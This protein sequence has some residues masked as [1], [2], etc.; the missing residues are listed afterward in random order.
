VRAVWLE[1]GQVDQGFIEAVAPGFDLAGAYEKAVSVA[2]D[3][4]DTLRTDAQAVAGALKLKSEI[5]ELKENLAANQ[6]RKKSQK[7]RRNAIW[8]EWKQLWQPLGIDPLDPRDMAAWAGR[9]GE[10]RLKAAECRAKMVAVAQLRD[11]M[12]RVGTEMAE[13]LKELGV[14]RPEKAG[15]TA[16]ADLAKQTK[17]HHDQLRKSRQELELRI[18]TLEQ[19][20]DDNQKRKAQAEQDIR[21]WDR[22]WTRAI[23]KLEFDTDAKPEDVNDF[24]LALD[25]VF[26]ELEKVKDKKQRIAGIQHNYQGY[27]KRIGDVLD[28]IAPDL[29]PLEATEA[30][31]ELN[32]RLDKDRAQQMDRKRFEQERRKKSD[33]LS[34]IKQ[35]LAAQREKLRL[36]CEDALT[37]KPEQL[38]EIE[39]R[40]AAHSK[41]LS[42]LDT[43]NERLAELALGQELKTFV[44]QVRV[45][46]PD[47]LVAK[48]GRLD[49]EKK[50]LLQEQKQLVEEIAVQKKELEAIGGD[51]LAAGIAEQVQGLSGKIASDVEH[52]IRLKLASMVLANAIERYRRLNQSPV[53][54]AASGY[55]KTITG[56]AFE[57]LRA[58]YDEK[59]DPVIKAFRSD[60]KPLM[61]HEMSDGSRDQ[62]FLA[63]RLGGLDKYVSANG[64][65][66]FIV[67]DVLVHFDDDR[68]AAALDAMSKLAQST[69]IIFFTHHRH[70]V[71]LAKTFL[72]DQTLQVHYL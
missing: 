35:E 17:G 34:Q 39:K 71:E 23:D 64:P 61:V 44:G 30:I 42:E 9:Q 3:T 14:G 66:P 57:G 11:D 33:L 38:P 72:D 21:I 51:S 53:L 1:G 60:G 13:R 12:D 5:R 7:G 2:D 15:Y 4:S 28:K 6:E 16:L 43:I 63:L 56:G 41:L 49:D 37:D 29:K 8:E 45:H 10:I 67:D 52:Y 36:L 62:L 48:L 32:D 68:S 19:E 59:G 22:E 27:A 24:V 54:E 46:D 20:I 55:F 18:C 25:Q 47:E 70:L 31:L 69:Q 26:G 50:G 65:M 40:A 58:D